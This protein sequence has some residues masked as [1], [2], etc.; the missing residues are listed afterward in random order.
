MLSR[1]PTPKM[2]AKK[3]SLPR[4]GIKK[5]SRALANA[6]A[7]PSEV[8][9][10]YALCSAQLDRAFDAF[11]EAARAHGGAILVLRF[12]KQGKMTLDATG[13]LKLFI[14]E[15][16]T[17]IVL[18]E[19]LQ[20]ELTQ[21]SRLDQRVM[22]AESVL[23]L[24][25]KSLAGV[26]SSLLREQAQVRKQAGEPRINTLEGKGRMWGVG[27]KDKCPL[28]YKTG[29]YCAGDKKLT[30]DPWDKVSAERLT[31]YKKHGQAF[32]LSALSHF[33]SAALLNIVRKWQ[34]GTSAARCGAQAHPGQQHAARGT[35]A[36]PL[37]QVRT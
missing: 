29:E 6:S 28:F 33:G 31:L 24:D 36:P 18:N 17:Q 26:V 11:S 4:M 2:A 19:I 20:C 10:A 21:S 13:F 3:A 8:Q 7:D 14:E 32:V 25:D 30:L 37:Q 15:P 1:M 12:D 22:T 27:S 16:R 9:R 35:R 5:A 23:N 34:S